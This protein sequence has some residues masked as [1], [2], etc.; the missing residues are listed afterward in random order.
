MEYNEVIRS[1]S[2]NQ[3]EILFNIMNLHN[4][5]KPFDCDM[6]YSS[7]K[8]Y[9]NFSIE[10]NDGKKMEIEIPQPKIKFDVCPQT[11]DTVQITPNGKLPLDDN[12]IESIVID[13]PFVI[14]PHDAPSVRNDNGDGKRNIIYNRFSSYYPWWT[15]FDSYFHWINEAYRVL[16]DGG[17]CVFKTQSTISGGKNLMTPYYSWMIAEKCGFYVLDEFILTAKNRLHSGKIKKQLHARKFHSHF[18]VFKKDS[19]QMP[20]DY[21]KWQHLNNKAHQDGNN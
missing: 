18:L 10:F 4:N 20:I 17:I 6:T 21:F 15:M 7:G 1:V 16:K 3:H 2:S 13:L 19:K 11:E 9:G 14:S 8:F 5:G 12:S